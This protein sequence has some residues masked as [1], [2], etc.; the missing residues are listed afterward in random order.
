MSDDLIIVI[1]LQ[2]L[3]IVSSLLTPLIMAVSSFIRRIEHS[4]CC[5]SEIDLSGDSPKEEKKKSSENTYL[6]QENINDLI[7]YE[8]IR[9][10]NL[11]K[12]SKDIMKRSPNI[13]IP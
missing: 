11:R 3:G 10:N 9:M 12:S 4:K 1:V 8:K 7:D 2:I 13:D 5:R 6:T